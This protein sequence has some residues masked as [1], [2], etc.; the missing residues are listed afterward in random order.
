MNP[1]WDAAQALLALA[2]ECLDANCEDYA[3]KYVT[4]SLPIADCS[5]LAVQIGKGRAQSGS[6]VGRGQISA[7]LDVVLIRC[8]EPVPDLTRQAGYTPPSPEAIEEANA[9]VARDAWQVFECVICQACDVLGAIKGV[10]AC[11]NEE[12]GPPEILWNVAGDCRSATVR[13]P[14]IF[15]ACC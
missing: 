3:R 13:V 9:C 12:T 1:M 15:G 5:T 11:C 4:T 2:I 14:M 10:G 7:P 6:C 8:C